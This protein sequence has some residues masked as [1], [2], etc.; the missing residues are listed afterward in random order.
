M[1]AMKYGRL[2]YF[3]IWTVL[4]LPPL[5]IH[6]SLKEAA[7]SLGS[8][9]LLFPLVR[10]KALL[11][12]A[13]L[14]LA[15]V[16]A[17]N[18]FHASFLG[19]LVDEFALATLMRTESQETQEFLSSL[20]T[21]SILK[22]LLWL[23]V[24]A[25][26][27]SYLWRRQ[28]QQGL[29]PS[30]WSKVLLGAPLV[31][32]AGLG[33]TGVV[34]HY[35]AEAYADQVRHVYPMQMTLAVMRYQ[36]LSGSV[37]YTPQ[38]PPRPTA[39]AAAQTLV[40]VIGESASS[41]R[42]SLLGYEGEDTNQALRSLPGLSLQAVLANG[43][44]TA[45]ALPFL[46]TGQSAL[47]SL[48]NQAPTF[49]D[50]ARQAGFKTFVFTNSRFFDKSEDIYTQALRRSA[51]IYQKVGNGALDEV[52]TT[53]LASALADASPHKLI[54]L[55]TYGS[56]PKISKR[57]PSFRYRGADTY[58][59]S[60]RY[61][62]DL[63]AEWIGMLASTQG[64]SALYYT[65]DH[66][67]GMPPCSQTYEHGF[68]RSTYEVPFMTWA[69]PQFQQT[70]PGLL[71]DRSGQI[72]HSTTL[73]PT[74]VAQAMGYAPATDLPQMQDSRVLLVEGLAYKDLF[75]KNACSLDG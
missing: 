72:V 43:K 20:K 74:L 35:D 17:A 49:I 32:W 7:Y 40:V 60:I 15:L 52:L 67:L 66:G 26:A 53:P 73:L 4:F 46:L 34:R 71:D 30:R 59:N 39:P 68:N 75:K 21:A 55:H 41:H 63:L 16:G 70:H 42:W 65:S 36:E 6:P 37:F 29:A 14:A 54:V 8:A 18:I 56:H 22:P 58:D 9:F 11:L 25:L 13:C 12:I 47:D 48:K 64:A 27:S 44:N 45:K 5:L 50:L 2:L 23:L 69:S 38:L 51:D 57:Y 3:A 62:S 33:I 24:C 19:S 10:H 61:T 1:D 31:L 28:A